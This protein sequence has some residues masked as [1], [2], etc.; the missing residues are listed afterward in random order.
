MVIIAKGPPSTGGWDQK[1][2]NWAKVPKGSL[3]SDI[4]FTLA[5]ISKKS[6][7]ITKL[8]DHQRKS[9]HLIGG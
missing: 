7:Q 6:C 9:L 1:G 3:I 2:G 5:Q 8:G 4:F